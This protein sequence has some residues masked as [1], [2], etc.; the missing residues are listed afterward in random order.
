[1]ATKVTAPLNRGSV[2]LVNFDP[3]IGSEIKKTR[4][5]VIIQ[6]DTSNKHSTVTIV[7]AI[8]SA[9]GSVPYP[10]EVFVKKGEGGLDCDSFVLLN[11]VRTVDRARLVKKLGTFKQNTMGSIDHAIE[12]SLG[13]VEL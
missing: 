5:A 4:P 8:S 1:M 2:Y 7:A 9:D 13:L 12:I 6:N 3:T 11:Q 10:N